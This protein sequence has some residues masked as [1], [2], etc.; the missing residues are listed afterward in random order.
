MSG[1]RLRRHICAAQHG[2]GT[3][4]QPPGAGSPVWGPRVLAGAGAKAPPTSQRE[5]RW[6]GLSPGLLMASLL[7]CPK[8]TRVEVTRVE[9]GPPK[10]EI[11]KQLGNSR[12]TLKTD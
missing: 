4:T 6:L 5:W 8:V 11:R 1:A 12:K 9:L 7:C 2:A 10:L 3:G